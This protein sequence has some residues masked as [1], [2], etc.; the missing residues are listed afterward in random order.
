MK[1]NIFFFYL[2]LILAGCKSISDFSTEKISLSGEW[3]FIIDSLDRGVE[4][5]WYNNILPEKVRLPG[6]MAENGKG[7]EV[8]VNTPWTG[9]I[10]DRSY[11]TEEKYAKYRRP[12]NIKIPFWLKPV[13]Y[14]KGVAWYQ[15]EVEIS[16][17]WKDKK[18]KLF[19]ERPHW[20]SGV[21]VNGIGAGSC[22]SLATPHEY[23]IST[24]L[25]SG[26]NLITVRI[27][28]RVIIPVGV[29]SHS[30]SDHTQGNWNGITGEISLRASSPVDISQI[31]IYPDLTEKKARV[32]VSVEGSAGS[33][34][35]GKLILSAGSFNSSA[36]LKV[37][38]KSVPVTMNTDKAEFIIEYP[39]GRKPLL[40]SE[41]D[42][43]MYRLEVI[44][45]ND[46]GEILDI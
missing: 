28:N 31:R 23:D 43:S 12:G 11:F 46:K 16:E 21:F 22:N 10:V 17:G 44:L 3:N 42:P 29:N 24:L 35:S 30:I 27:D 32:I 33:R 38:R 15:K 2:I 5:G 13:K 20:E 6:S 19:L 4:E 41:F 26:K 36:S 18:V 14:Y 39:M 45:K 40:W 25:K 8:G 37:K 34:F 7:N 9:D 1:T